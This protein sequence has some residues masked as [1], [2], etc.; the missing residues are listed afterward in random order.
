VIQE[1]AKACVRDIPDFPKPGIL[2]RDLTPLLAR[3]DLCS[4]IDSFFT[5]AFSTFHVDAVA[6]LE[7]R[8]FW[9]GPSISRKLKVPFIP[10]RKKGKLPYRT[11]ERSYA[12]EYGQA[13]V[14]MHVDA[15]KPGMR[16]L[17]H[18]DL[19]ATGGSAVAAAELI[20]NSGGTVAGFCFL[21]E[22]SD[23]KGRERLNRFSPNIVSLITY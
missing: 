3:P 14:E 15:V 11:I 22:I 1:K 20:E 12:L 21:V 5:D 9:F 17:I 2:F 6:A 18:D 10:I 13:V 7:A 4:D 23:L 8:G 19:I 16:I